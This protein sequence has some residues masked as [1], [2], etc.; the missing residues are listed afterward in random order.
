MLDWYWYTGYR[1]IRIYL[2]FSGIMAVFFDLKELVDLMSIGTLTA[3]TLVATS[4][5]LLRWLLSLLE[6]GNLRILNEMPLLRELKK[7]V[8]SNTI[9][10]LRYKPVPGIDCEKELTKEEI[11]YAVKAEEAE[12]VI[13]PNRRD[14]FHVIQLIRPASRSPTHLTA[15]IVS[16]ATAVLGKTLW[17]C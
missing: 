6:I 7:N 3:Y 2:C 4:V 11:H 15:L 16:C 12:V 1:S 9:F 8:V 13:L 5:L 17:I 14:S 10:I